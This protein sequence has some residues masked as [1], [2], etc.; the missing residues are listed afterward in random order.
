[1]DKVLLQIR[2]MKIREVSF[3]SYITDK[4]DEGI[5]PGDIHIGLTLSLRP[6]LEK[7][8]LELI[9]GVRYYCV[10][11]CISR[12]LLDYKISMLYSIAGLPDYVEVK[13]ETSVVKSELLSML[14]AWGIGSLRGMLALRTPNTVLD[15]YPLPVIPLAS[16][17]AG[18]QSDPLQDMALSP[19]FQF[20]I[21]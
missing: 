12:N 7:E 9:T 20:Q 11:S 18:L 15:D 4:F 6:D 19:M 2:L 16:L 1:M 17:I 8:E 5:K 21:S 10:S 13:G 3:Q 14:L